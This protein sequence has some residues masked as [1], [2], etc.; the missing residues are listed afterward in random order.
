MHHR[1]QAY[2]NSAL[3]KVKHICLQGDRFSGFKLNTISLKQLDFLHDWSRQLTV[4]YGTYI[5][6]QPSE[7]KKNL[8]IFF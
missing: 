4:T 8:E 6:E 1:L 5:I 3:L 2:S 7:V